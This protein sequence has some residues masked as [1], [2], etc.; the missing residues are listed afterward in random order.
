MIDKVG[1]GKDDPGFALL[2]YLGVGS[3]TRIGDG[4]LVGNVPEL[5]WWTGYLVRDSRIIG[6][7]LVVMGDAFC[8]RGQKD[9]VLMV[10][11]RLQLLHPIAVLG[12]TVWQIGF[13]A[14]SV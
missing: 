2:G 8:R 13:G 3:A 1:F 6:F 11:A 10:A 7:A 14:R 12:H 5:V 4:N 9:A